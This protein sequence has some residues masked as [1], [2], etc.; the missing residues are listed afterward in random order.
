MGDWITSPVRKNMGHI[1]SNV[2]LKRNIHNKLEISVPELIAIGY[3]AE[4]AKINDIRAHR[5]V[6]QT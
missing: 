1:S 4:F 5:R 3:N 2:M 6:I